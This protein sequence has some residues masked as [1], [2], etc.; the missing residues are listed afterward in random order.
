MLK[1]PKYLVQ[2]VHDEL[3]Y[4]VPENEA[5]EY[6]DYLAIE[7]VDYRHE[8]PYTVTGKIGKTW[9][10]IKSLEDVWQDDYEDE[11]DDDA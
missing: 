10:D 1:C 7:L 9:G 3:L 4:L 5:Q 11:G 6:Y 2:Q 8:L